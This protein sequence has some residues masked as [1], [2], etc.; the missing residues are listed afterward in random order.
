M[1]KI[2]LSRSSLSKERSAKINK[3]KNV[4]FL[5]HLCVQ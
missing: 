2:S 1:R 5:L 4:N 3:I